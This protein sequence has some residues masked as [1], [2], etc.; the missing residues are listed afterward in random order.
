MWVVV[1]S[2]RRDFPR[3][4]S[5]AAGLPTPDPSLKGGET[6]CAA[7]F[8]CRMVS[9]T[10]SLPFRGGLGRVGEGLETSSVTH[11]ASYYALW[12]PAVRS[13]CVNLRNFAGET[14]AV[15][16]RS[17]RAGFVPICVTS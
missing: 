1:D 4:C 3:G 13:I 9:C 11:K 12:R 16:P 17:Y 14:C 5:L 7:S 8:L 6:Y 2:C 10:D 15:C